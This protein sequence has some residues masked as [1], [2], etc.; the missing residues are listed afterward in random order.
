MLFFRLLGPLEA[1]DGDRQV[2]LG[3]QRQRSLLALLLLSANRVVPT[4]T[5]V[6]ALWGEEPPR[7]A[8][9]SLHN[10]VSQL[11]RALGPD[12]LQTRPP[13]YVLQVPPGGLD[14]VEFERLLE[15]A[16][17]EPP[18]QRSRTLREALSLWGGPALADVAF[19]RFATDEVRRLEE[20]RLVANEERLEA[21]LAAGRAGDVV[22]ELEGL[23]AHHPYRERLRAL[24]MLALYRSNRQAEALQVFHDLRRVLDEELG[25]EPGP[26]LRELHRRILVQ[27]ASL[28]GSARVAASSPDHHAAIQRALISSRLVPVMGLKTASGAPDPANAAERLARTFGCPAEVASSLTRV[29]Q[30]VTV[31]HGVGPLYD[32]LDALYGSDYEPGAA[33]RLLASLPPLLRE[34]ELPQQLIVTTGYDTTLER[35]FREAGEPLDVVSY[36]ALGPD[37]GK[38]LH[39]TAEGSARVIDEPNLEIGLTTDERTILLKIHGGSGGYG[40][41]DRESYVVSE[42]DYIDFLAGTQASGLLPVG[43]AARLRRSHFLFLGY[44]LEEWTLRVFLRRLWGEERLAYRSWAVGSATDRLAAEYWRRRGVEPIDIEL[45][46][47]VEELARRLADRSETRA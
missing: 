10:A 43:L 6:D 5:L 18:E 21:D 4:D 9:T 19:E 36:I 11:R 45:D 23:V 24:L 22:A 31:T 20:L 30:Y 47:F 1:W 44:E 41:R 3:G 14:L 35:A 33:H 46:P 16:R 40:D 26:E 2:D 42:D 15:R 17:S 28:H 39:L 25:L 32:E 38:F 8:T 37:R 12:V 27:D 13:G 34:R 29:A 7:T